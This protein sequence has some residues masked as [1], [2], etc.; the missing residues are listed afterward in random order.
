VWQRNVF[1]LIIVFVGTELQI[2]RASWRQTSTEI[3]NGLVQSL[4]SF[5]VHV[6]R[7]TR[8][9]RSIHNVKHLV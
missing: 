2:A 8:Q 4:A 5:I 3:P 7:L 6:R 1:V 9:C